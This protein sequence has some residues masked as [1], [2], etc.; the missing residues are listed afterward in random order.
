[1]EV[2][3]HGLHHHVLVQINVAG[4]VE[5]ELFAQFR[6]RSL[7]YLVFGVV[8]VSTFDWLFWAINWI[9]DIFGELVP[10]HVAVTV[11]VNVLEKLDKAVDKLEALVVWAVQY[12]L[13]QE[14]KCW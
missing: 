12:W 5:F 3:K 14:D 4:L 10:L 6:I 2:V 11:Q 7:Y 9:N 8:I 1:M 13:H